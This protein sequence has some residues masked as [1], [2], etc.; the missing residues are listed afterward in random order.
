MFEVAAGTNSI[1]T[2]ADQGFRGGSVSSPSLIEDGHGNFFGIT[3]GTLFEVAAG[4][5]TFTTAC[6]QPTKSGQS[7]QPD[8]GQ[9][10][11]FLCG[12]DESNGTVFEVAAGNNTT[13]ILANFPDVVLNHVEDNPKPTSLIGDNNGNLFGTTNVG[14]AEIIMARCSRYR[15]ALTSGP[16]RAQITCGAIP[17]IGRA[18]PL[19]ACEIPIFFIPQRYPAADHRQ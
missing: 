6:L 16:A 11:Q 17:L 12:T 10:R 5:S 7:Q 1:T 9:P 4:S 14:G 18:T 3:G 13:N 15:R 19:P 8:R 2:R